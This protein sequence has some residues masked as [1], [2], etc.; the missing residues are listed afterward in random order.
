MFQLFNP[1]VTFSCWMTLLLIVIEF[2]FF[3]LQPEAWASSLQSGFVAASW[4]NLVFLLQLATSTDCSFRHMQKHFMST[5]PQLFKM[6]AIRHVDSCRGV[7]VM[8]NSHSQ[9][10]GNFIN[11]FHLSWLNLLAF[12]FREKLIRLLHVAL[13]S[14]LKNILRM[15]VKPVFCMLETRGM[16]SKISNLLVSVVKTVKCKKLKSSKPQI[17]LFFV[18]GTKF[19]HFP[20]V[21]ETLTEN[22]L[23]TSGVLLPF[24]SC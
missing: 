8:N 17:V 7:I 5:P 16:I 10:F 14:N 15:D 9:L 1:K 20:I 21:S 23:R 3:Y 13:L 4:W 6:V 18:R 2:L 24:Q 22:V 19:R 12:L 11:L